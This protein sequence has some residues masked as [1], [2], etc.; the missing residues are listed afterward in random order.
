MSKG[1][2]ACIDFDGV[3]ADYRGG[4]RGENVFGDLLPGARDGILS[5]KDNG[6]KIII[7]TARRD[8]QAL[9]DYLDDNGIP[10][11]D[12]NNVCDPETGRCRKPHADVYIDDRAIRFDGDWAE[13][14]TEVLGFVPWQKRPG[15]GIDERGREDAYEQVRQI[16]TILLH[17]L[18]ETDPDREYR[19]EHLNPEYW[20]MVQV[21]YPD[22]RVELMRLATALRGAPK[23]IMT[24]L[25]R[26]PPEYTVR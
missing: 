11:D 22:G 5:L 2:T 24:L 17:Y 13:A 4:W 23:E 18:E 14:V 12:V 15:Y 9:R 7:N 20:N 3:I 10:F 6:Y 26:L 25:T 19:L 16:H 1:K 8:T 21:T